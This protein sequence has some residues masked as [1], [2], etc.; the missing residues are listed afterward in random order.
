M[1]IGRQ[2]Q[3]FANVVIRDAADACGMSRREFLE[4]VNTG[5]PEATEEL[6]LSILAV[7]DGK[8][9]VIDIERLK[10]ILA[11]ILDFI[12]RLLELFKAFV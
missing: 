2:E 7:S 1:K 10:E 4:A 8:P 11:M 6:R 5:D 12:R 3:K 9:E